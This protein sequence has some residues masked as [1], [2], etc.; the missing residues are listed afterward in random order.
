MRVLSVASEVFPFVKTGGLGDVVAALPPALAREGVTMR[1]LVPGY[2][3]VVDALRGAQSVHE[4]A[5][6]QGEPAR[7]LAAHAAGLDLLVLDAPHL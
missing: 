4:Y 2:P 5:N 6:L 1:T 7:L 3:G